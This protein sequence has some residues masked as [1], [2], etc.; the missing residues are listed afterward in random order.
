MR[1]GEQRRRQRA[2]AARSTN[3]FFCHPPHERLS[4]R[5][6]GVRAAWLV[7]WLPP[8]TCHRSPAQE[9]API[10]GSAPAHDASHLP[11]GVVAGLAA[12]SKQHVELVTMP[13]FPSPPPHGTHRRTNTHERTTHRS[14]KRGFVGWLA[15]GCDGSGR[16]LTRLLGP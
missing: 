3:P 12:S 1:E 16:E 7:G 4:E 13:R 8:R 14:G 9:P 10:T 11:S 6:P 5:I 15:A 2:G